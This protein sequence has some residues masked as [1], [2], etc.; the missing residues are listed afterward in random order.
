M[1]R[2][3]NRQAITKALIELFK[4]NLDGTNPL[5]MTNVYGNVSSR[6]LFF[7]DIN[8]FPYI[9]VNPGTEVRGYTPATK[10]GDLIIYIRI[11]ERGDDSQDKLERLLAD[12]EGVLDNND[13]FSFTY[14][15]PDGL[16]GF[17]DQVGEIVK[18]DVGAIETDQGL[19]FPDAFAEMALHIKYEIPQF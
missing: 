10:W 17:T 15:V 5:Y 6:A 2:S 18:C 13:D 14:S 11:F 4:T 12:V 1:A 8:D 7:E 19:F 3:T 9:S 16:G